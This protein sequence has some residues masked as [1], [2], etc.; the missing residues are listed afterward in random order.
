MIPTSLPAASLAYVL[1]LLAG[2]MLMLL[3]ASYA[4]QKPQRDGNH[5]FAYLCLAIAIYTMFYALEVISPT[6]ERAMI[7]N[8]LQY[9]GISALP[10]L[11]VVFIIRFTGKG[12]WLSPFRISL[13]FIIPAITLTLKYTDSLH[14]LIYQQVEAE[15]KIG[16]TVIHI[17]PGFWYWVHLVYINLAILFSAGVLV[18][19]FYQSGRIFRKQALIMMVGFI[20][21]YFGH[22]I[23]QAGYSYQGMDSSPIYFSV[24]GIFTALGIF[25][26]GMLDLAPIAREN[27]F[28]NMRD[29]VA[30]I[31]NSYRIIDANPAIQN[32]YP[33]SKSHFRQTYR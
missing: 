32:L 10:A 24:F 4:F 30:V 7:W 11:A 25:R 29:G 16:L 12:D 20:A 31:D 1:L 19:F 5:A 8:R 6:I 3:L 14:G 23:Y 33:D 15:Q 26:Y 28:E 13:L 2:G 17:I 22:I 18:R 27:I 9:I 21:P